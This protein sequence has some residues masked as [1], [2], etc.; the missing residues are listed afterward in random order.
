MELDTLLE[1]DKWANQKIFKSIQ[2][3]KSY[4]HRSEMQKLF[5]HLLAAQ[6][7]WMDRITGKPTELGIWP[8]LTLQEIEKLLN[9]NPDQL[10][11]LISE[12]DE[13]ISYRNSKG[14][15]FQNSVEHI[16]VHLTI[17][18]QH[19][20]A[21]IAKLLRTAGITPPGTD[22]IFFIRTI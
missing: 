4:D 19:H 7:I 18:G 13:T 2:Q 17:H 12:K 10:K 9:E 22:F 3:V 6:K 11:A 8:D 21:Q 15:Q 14:E 20:R 16:L 1:Y 5:A